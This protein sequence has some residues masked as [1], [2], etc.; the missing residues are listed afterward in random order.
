M[1]VGNAVLLFL[2]GSDTIFGSLIWLLRLMAD[3]K[4]VQDKVYAEI[5]SVLGMDG[6]AK[7]E[8]RDLIPY[9]FAVLMETQRY[10]DFVTIFASRKASEDI[11]I[12]GY[13]IPKG[14]Y[15]TSNIWTIHHDPNYWEEPHKFIPERFLSN[16]GT[17]L[18]KNPSSFAPFSIGK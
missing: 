2:G 5:K 18:E 3:R 4:D 10:S 7:Y 17:K 11:H 12:K 9:T 13:T 15:I 1:L 14:S 16:N 6:K 8:E